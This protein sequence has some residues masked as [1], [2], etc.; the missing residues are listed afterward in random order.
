M[1]RKTH[2]ELGY[3]IPVKIRK[4]PGRYYFGWVKT[5]VPNSRGNL[6]VYYAGNCR[7]SERDAESCIHEPKGFVTIKTETDATRI[8]G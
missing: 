3:V 4:E 7:I 5:L 8:G 6:K 1:A 2:D